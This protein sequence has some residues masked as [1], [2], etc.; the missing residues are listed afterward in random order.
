MFIMQTVYHMSMCLYYI[1]I[2]F[3]SDII[4]SSFLATIQIVNIVIVFIARV[5]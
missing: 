4:I 5:R 3:I 2:S 1:D